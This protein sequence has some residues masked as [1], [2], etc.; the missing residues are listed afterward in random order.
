MARIWNLTDA[1]DS[2]PIDLVLFDQRARPGRYVEIPDELAD[3]PKLARH[4]AAGQLAIGDR[5]PLDY[6][7][8]KGA[9]RA[10]RAPGSVSAHGEQSSSES[11]ALPAPEVVG[12][13]PA[14]PRGAR[15]RRAGEPSE[16][17]TVG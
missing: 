1:P 16:P 14:E 5:P 8:A 10:E 15:R 4:L 9:I 11:P 6:Q 13:E 2:Q 17:P 7:L 3:D 12:S